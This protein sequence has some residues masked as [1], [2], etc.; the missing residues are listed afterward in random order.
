MERT[1]YLNAFYLLQLINKKFNLSVD[2][3]NV[4]FINSS[5][6]LPIAAIYSVLY[7]DNT[8]Y[9]LTKK[10]HLHCIKIDAEHVVYNTNYISIL[11]TIKSFF[12][13]N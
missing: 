12:N 10:K 1:D 11:N 7:T 5:F 6:T 9:I 13:I 2:F 8:L 3:D 4:C